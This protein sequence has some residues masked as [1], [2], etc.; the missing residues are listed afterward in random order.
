MQLLRRNRR[1]RLN[2][3]RDDHQEVG[4][5]V[6]DQAG[7]AVG[8][9]GLVGRAELVGVV[10]EQVLEVELALGVELLEL[11]LGALAEAALDRLAV[12]VPARRSTRT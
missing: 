10:A 11:D 12:E 1:I 7:D 2:L 8:L 3:L 9:V 4:L 6:G 5:G